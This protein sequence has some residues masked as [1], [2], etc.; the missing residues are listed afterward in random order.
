MSR[1][2]R[3]GL[4]ILAT[5]LVFAGAIFWIGSKRFMFNSTYRLNAEF[6]NVAGLNDG[7]EV[8]V[9]G[10]AEGTIK[11]IELPRRVNEKVRVVM[12]MKNAPREVVKTDSVAAIK[13][14]GL[15]GDKYV[16]VSFGS[17]QAAK[18]KS[19]D[20][21]QSEPPLQISDLIK[22]T[23]S[24]LNSAQ[25]TM[26]SVDDTAGNLKNISSKINQGSGTV[27][28]LVNDRTVYEHANAAASALQDDAEALKHNFLLRGFFKTRGYEDSTDLTKHEIPALPAK[29]SFKTFEYDASKVFDKPDTAKLKKEKLLADA[30]K[31]LEENRFGLA[32]VA[33]YVDGKRDTEKDQLLSEARAMVVRDYL[34]KNFKLDDTR[35]KTIGLGKAKETGATGVLQILVY[36]EGTDAPATRS[37]APGKH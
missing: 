28:A 5:M 8:R 6:Q 20:S 12:D 3:L 23:D 29:P 18:V 15:V 17:D 30:G 27:G 25:G 14:E 34:V 24:I 32:V 33:D 19:G 35:I 11:R 7:A 10:I 9:G 31:F 26:Q 16:E 37:S 21:I 4:F 2:F 22:K 13:S 1:A 36:P